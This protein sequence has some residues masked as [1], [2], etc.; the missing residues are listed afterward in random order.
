M[1]DLIYIAANEL[2]TN[3]IPGEKDN[4]QIVAYARESGIEWVDDDETP[5]C[6]IFMNWCAVKA[7]LPRPGEKRALARS[8][9][10]VGM[11]TD[12]PEH[13]DIAVFWRE[14]ESSKKGHVG[15]FMGYNKNGDYVYTLG[16]NQSRMVSISEYP[17]ERVLS[18]RRLV[19]TD[20][21]LPDEVISIGTEGDKVS[22]LQAVLKMLDYNAGPT[23]GIYGQKTAKAVKA[24]Q[25][26]HRELGNDGIY[27]PNTRE[28]LVKALESHQ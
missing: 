23:D 15:I 28:Y 17:V 3:A 21:N 14:S 22:D 25:S 8:W 26:Q 13:G 11:P 12:N 1:N 6:S 5:W 4:D 2:G 9:E 19:E 18:F 16:G 20:I 7:G 27:G 24:F 10:N